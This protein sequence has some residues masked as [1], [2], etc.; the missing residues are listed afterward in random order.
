M[1]KQ[2][3]F[4]RHLSALKCAGGI[5][6]LLAAVLLLHGC[7]KFSTVDPAI[8]PRVLMTQ[9]PPGQEYLVALIE[10][11]DRIAD[12]APAP[13]GLAPPRTA[14]AGTSRRIIMSAATAD[15]T[16]VYGELT[17]EGLGAVVTERHQ[18]PKGILLITVRKTH[19]TAGG[20]VVWE[21]KKYITFADLTSDTPQ[22]STTTE[23]AGL[24]GDTI[25]THVVR[26]GILETF[27]FRLPVVTRVVN[28]SD[29]S[30]RV[31][32]RFGSGGAVVSEVRDGSGALIQLRRNNGLADGSIANY[33][34]FAD[35]TWRNV[36]TVGEADGTV[37]REIT[38]GP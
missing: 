18:Y 7:G 22:Q 27:T 30:V 35:S 5:S 13:H 14:S 37:F 17:P 21:T 26:N 6:G 4:H 24:S 25:L 38:S 36:R 34:L 10:E 9:K 28:P 3:L 11:L 12:E 31:T 32:A 23:V 15:T 20:G 2:R 29:G 33:T 19:G 16:F 8:D 1:F